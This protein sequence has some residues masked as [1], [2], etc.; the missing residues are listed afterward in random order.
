MRSAQKKNGGASSGALLLAA[1]LFVVFSFGAASRAVL[2]DVPVPVDEPDTAKNGESNPP[3]TDD[4]KEE[5]RDLSP[6]DYVQS[7]VP[8]NVLVL[9][10]TD[11]ERDLLGEEGDG[12]RA[13]F[14]AWLSGV[15]GFHDALK[16][17]VVDNTLF[18][19]FVGAN[20][21]TNGIMKVVS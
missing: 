18:V 11:A 5:F 2:Q 10:Q 12:A 17:E 7:C 6:F 13:P 16:T 21:M 8:V 9:A 4:I 14:G 15:P 20:F 3:G 1:L 19:S